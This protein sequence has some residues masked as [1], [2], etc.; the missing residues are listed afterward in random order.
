MKKIPFTLFAVI[1]FIASTLQASAQ[2]EQTRQ[3]SGFNGIASS[4]SFNVHVKID[5]TE[6][7]KL[8]AAANV[9]NDIE[10]VVENNKL[11][12]RFKKDISWHHNVGKID[13]YVTAKALN[14]L[15]NS[16]S[17]NIKVD[18]ELH[19]DDVNLKISGSGNIT[20]SV[21]SNELHASISGSGS[22]NLTGNSSNADLVISGS[23]EIR[24]SQFKAETTAVRI[25]GSGNAHITADKAISAHISGSGN[26]T[27]S[28]NASTIDIRT[29]GSG[30]VTRTSL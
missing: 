29:T 12:I 2:T 3:V 8:I 16:G 5:G 4:G 27:Y 28:G 24:A 25:S 13:V 23:G 21:K 1:L 9:I 10:T 18:G 6:S 20:S 7:L 11:M 14:D 17:G 15:S 30:R 22:I 19:S 26:L